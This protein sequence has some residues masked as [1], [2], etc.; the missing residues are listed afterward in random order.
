M[1]LIFEELKRR[2]LSFLPS[3]Y[4]C[5]LNGEKLN[6]HDLGTPFLIAGLSGSFAL[7]V[8]A[9]ALLV[10]AL[11]KRRRNRGS[12]DLAHPQLGG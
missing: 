3:G 11:I 9:V 4:T 10:H 6:F 2:T 8:T 7:L 5:T 12:A 1:C